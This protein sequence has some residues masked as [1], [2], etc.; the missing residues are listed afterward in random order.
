MYEFLKN[1]N[2]SNIIILDNASTYPPLLDWYS[3]LA[4]KEVV[5]FPG[6]YG[7]HCLF[8]SGYLKHHCDS[9]YIVYSDSDLEL[10]PL[11][12]DDFLEIMKA[13]LLKYN[14]KKI[15]LA[16]RI[17]DVPGS[18]YRNCFTG[19][20]EHEKQFWI[21]ELEKDVYRA[22]VDTTFCLLRKPEHHDLRALRIAGNF[23]ARHL[24]WYFEYSTLNEEEKYFVENANPQS[25]FR[26][27]YLAWLSENSPAH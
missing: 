7:A 19:S 23:T 2:F 11:M 25:N 12:P 3:T 27:G 16:L 26:N 13:T 21:H 1:R 22:M 17:D 9:E 10:N 8:D 15:G 4:E 14:E 24:P 5:R 20:I 6:N 18:C